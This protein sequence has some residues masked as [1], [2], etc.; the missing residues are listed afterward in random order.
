ML[1]WYNMPPFSFQFK[2]ECIDMYEIRT[3]L[4][5]LKLGVL[6]FIEM[7][8]SNVFVHYANFTNEQVRS[9]IELN[10]KLFGNWLFKIHPQ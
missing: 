10:G 6:H 4:A 1:L 2:C 7:K 5:D 3:R 9:E 8:N